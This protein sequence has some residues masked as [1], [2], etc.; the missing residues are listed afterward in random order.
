MTMRFEDVT[1]R[2]GATI[3]FPGNKDD[4]KRLNAAIPSLGNIRIYQAV[5]GGYTW[6]ISYDP[7]LPS[8]T[9][10]EL[11]QYRGYTASY[12]KI[13]HTDS[14]KTVRIDG[15][16]WASMREAEEACKAVFRQ[17]RHAN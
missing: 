6:A 9:A 16:P 1:H 4:G 8:W 14:S 3:R 17:I 11:A 2:L 12:R 7:G 5:H 15:G 13:G 10:E